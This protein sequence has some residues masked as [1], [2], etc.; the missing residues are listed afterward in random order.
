MY[1]GDEIGMGDN[2]YLGD[3]DGVRTPMQWTPDRNGGFS[4]ADFAQLYL[5]PILDPVHGFQAVNV[6]AQLRSPS[7]FLQWTHRMLEVRRQHPVFGV[8]DFQVQS[9]TNASALAFVRECLG[10]DGQPDIVLCVF[11]LSRF[12]Q[13]CE[14]Y[15]AQFEGYTPHELLGRVPFPPIGELPYFVTLPPY[16]FFWFELQAPAP[17]PPS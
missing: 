1:Y 11:N 10:D 4:R 13:P 3:R 14:L 12:A 16:G 8:G 6:E 5:P 17:G 15:L 2:I 7:S 9:A